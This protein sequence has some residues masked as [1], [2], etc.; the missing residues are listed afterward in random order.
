[1][2]QFGTFFRINLPT[3]APALTNAILL[4]IVSGLQAFDVVLI[5]GWPF[6]LQVI[7]TQIMDFTNGAGLSS[8]AHA[9]V[10]SIVLIAVV[11]ILCV[12]QARV[13]GSRSFITVSGKGGSHRRI[14]LT[15]SRYLFGTLIFIYL[16]LAAILPIG[17]VVFTSFQP[18]PGVYE[19]FSL[20]HYENVLATPR[21]LES[22]QATFTLAIATGV[23]TMLLAVVVART[24]QRVGVKIGTALRFTTL[25]PLAMP[26]V[27]T[28]LAISW[29][30]LSLPGFKMLYGTGYLVM[31]A[32][33]ICVTPFAVQIAHS[34]IAQIAPELEESARLS[35][36]SAPQA[37]FDIV[38]RLI[39]P[40]FLA[41]W[42]MVA[43]IVTGN[44]E[45]P[46]L[47]K[48]PGLNP[49]AMLVYDLNGRGNFSGASAL[50]VVLLLAKAAVWFAGLAL[51]K[52]LVALARWRQRRLA[53]V[54]AGR[55]DEFSLSLRGSEA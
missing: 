33:I 45:I 12:I 44:L 18:F 37:M 32:L 22:I 31:I 34:A 23:I 1:V 3:L 49:I 10:L 47:L 19:N 28:A 8:Y 6:K 27:V 25:I 24:V 30:F 42:F 43:I 16:L 46:L 54:V 36:A 40:S 13:L 51:F 39:A 53:A 7:S 11:A 21:V 29:G 5:L 4:G 20:Q 9:S 2:G 55:A 35:G 48:A 52:L 26:G 15:R 17:S 41:G 38:M 14:R 50:L